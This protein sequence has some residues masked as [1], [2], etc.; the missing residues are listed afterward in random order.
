[1]KEGSSLLLPL[2]RSR[3]QAEAL[4]AVLLNPD[5]EWSLTQ[6]AHLVGASLPTVQR[7]IKRAE[8]A[9][10]VR[11][12]RLG[13]TRLVR[14]NPEGALT[15]PLAELLLQSLGPKQVLA[16]ALAGIA[17]IDAAYIFGS[18]AAR[19]LGERGRAPEDVD[20]LVIGQPDRD[21]LDEALTRVEQRLALPV[22]VAIR[23]RTWW[24]SG[25][26]AFRKE[27]AKRPIVELELDDR[28]SATS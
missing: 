17:G 19:Y 20:V 18:W 9:G 23:R 21:A 27:I 13:N 12:R 25:D 3:V 1:M 24:E 28:A 14:A 5:R 7:E 26:D 15:G 2:L 6:L 11:S 22:Q 16:E 8:D 4:S 10:V